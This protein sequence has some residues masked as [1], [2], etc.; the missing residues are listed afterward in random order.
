MNIKS[1]PVFSISLSSEEKANMLKLGDTF[2]P[3]VEKTVNVISEHPEIMPG[4]FSVAGFKRDFNLVKA[5][6][7]I[8]QKLTVLLQSVN[9]ALT[10]AGSDSLVSGLEVY[11][12]IKSHKDKIPGLNA[13]Y[14]ELKEYFPRRKGLAKNQQQPPVS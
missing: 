11:S 7:P 9:D 6:E 1:K 13:I 2:R 4:T 10:A 5:L 12:E 14:N 3:L 8:Q